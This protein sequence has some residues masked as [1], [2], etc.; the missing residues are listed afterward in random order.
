MSWQVRATEDWREGGLTSAAILGR[1]ITVT[2]AAP[3]DVA[4]V[5]HSTWDTSTQEEA[6]LRLLETYLAA[7]DAGNANNLLRVLPSQSGSFQI[8]SLGG[9]DMDW[10]GDD[11][12]RLDADAVVAT[13][14][15]LS[16]LNTRIVV[17]NC[18]SRTLFRDLESVRITCDFTV[19]SELLSTYSQSE[20]PGT[21]EGVV[22]DGV[23]RQV[24][25][26][27]APSGPM[28]QM[29]VESTVG[30][31]PEDRATLVRPSDGVDRFEP[32]FS[33][34]TAATHL[35]FVTEFVA[36][37]LRPGDTR[38]VETSL[39][40]ME[41]IWMDQLPI[42][43]YAIP[44]I[45][46]LDGGFVAVGEGIPEEWTEETS[47][48]ITDDG[49]EWEQIPGPERVSSM[50]NLQPF[51]DGLIGQAWHQES[52]FLVY[53]DGSTWTTINLPEPPNG[54]FNDVSQ[55]AVSGDRLMV[56]TQYWSG[57]GNELLDMQAW[58]LG[59]DGAL[60]LV[61]LLPERSPEEETL[62]LVGYDEG[63]LLAS[64][65]FG[66][67]R[68]M[69]V[70]SSTD[71]QTWTE[72]GATTT[73]DEAT[74][75]WNLQRHRDKFFVVGEGAETAC[76]TT[77]SGG[78]ECTRRVGMWSSPDGTNWARVFTSSGESVSSYE[79]GSGTLGLVAV[80]TESW[81]QAQIPR[82]IY[83]SGDG[84]EW[85]RAGALNLFYPGNYWWWIQRPAVGTD[86]VL[87]PGSAFD[88]SSEFDSDAPFLI[89]GRLVDS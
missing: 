80:G 55:I 22:E 53:F 74:Y 25:L 76:S 60:E 86:T 40:T 88:Q 19:D 48:W 66:S 14:D 3:A 87:L 32:T 72:L 5:W 44:W 45:A 31:A 29:L 2:G 24:H 28:W 10:W 82:P 18:N 36:G 21:A 61:A 11:G 8:P 49:V 75:V 4:L 69:V 52:Q 1:N 79:I 38:V 17:E 73:L 15:Y 16:A 39:G 34:H 65:R 85:E 23:L 35:R 81:D 6:G 57:S 42:P 46:P 30:A 77:E 9:S 12:T 27:A 59:N 89:V 83:L 26:S 7:A 68:Q 20:N 71:G 54:R 84:A 63:F 43:V 67:A 13:L 56:L 37:L 64:A 41:W 47:L 50:W 58:M 33:G 51:R 78:D 62:G 70:W